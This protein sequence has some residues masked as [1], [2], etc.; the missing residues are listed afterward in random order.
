M[1]LSPSAG[2]AAGLLLLAAAPAA[3][4]PTVTVRV[5]GQKGTRLERTALTLGSEGVPG[6][7]CTG[8]SAGAALDLATHGD[9]NRGEFVTTILGE[10]HAYP[11]PDYW[12]EWGCHGSGYKRGGGVC[13]DHLAEGDELL[14]LVDFASP[15]TFAPQVFPLDL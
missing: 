11:S 10:T 4:A 5:E 12:G 7:S 9:W 3:A 13:A 8:D 2:L 6:T 14:M 1:K 15:T